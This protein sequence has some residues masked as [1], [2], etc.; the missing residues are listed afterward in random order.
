MDKEKKE[1][2]GEK[3]GCQHPGLKVA[4]LKICGWTNYIADV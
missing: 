2:G 4:K 3:Q 1:R